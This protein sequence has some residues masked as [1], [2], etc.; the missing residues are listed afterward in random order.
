MAKLL[1]TGETKRYVISTFVELADSVLALSY[2]YPNLKFII[3][4]HG[5][6]NE[7]PPNVLI[8]RP[9]WYRALYMAGKVCAIA[10][11]T[12][13]IGLIVPKPDEIGLIQYVNAFYLGVKSE[14]PSAT[15]GL[16]TVDFWN[17]S[18]AA[19]AAA[20]SLIEWGASCMTA[21]QG[22]AV[23]YQVF[24]DHNLPSVGLA[25]NVRIFS[26]DMVWT[27]FLID[28]GPIF[29]NNLKQISNDTLPFGTTIMYNLPEVERGDWGLNVE[30]AVRTQVDAHVANINYNA[31]FALFCKDAFATL[32]IPWPDNV[33]TE[34][35][36]FG[37]LLFNPSYIRVSPRV[38]LVAEWTTESATNRVYWRY[39]SAMSIIILCVAGVLAVFC[40]YVMPHIVYYRDS[41]VYSIASW[42]VVLMLPIACLFQLASIVPYL[43]IPTLASCN[44]RLWLESIGTILLLGT[45]LA[46]N[47]KHYIW[48]RNGLTVLTK[49]YVSRFTVSPYELFVMWLLPL[50]LANFCI[51]VFYTTLTPLVPKFPSAPFLPLGS[52][53]SQCFIVQTRAA[54]IVWL[55]YV[56]LLAVANLC[57]LYVLKN[58]PL[59]GGEVVATGAIVLNTLVF[60]GLT[61]FVATVVGRELVTVSLIIWLKVLV[62]AVTLIVLVIP[63]WWA[64]Q[65]QGVTEE[66][67]NIEHSNHNESSSLASVSR[68]PKE[69][70]PEFYSDSSVASSSTISEDEEDIDDH[71]TP[72]SPHSNF[73]DAKRAKA[74]ASDSPTNTLAPNHVP[75]HYSPP[76]SSSD[77]ESDTGSDLH[78][79]AG[80]LPPIIH[81]E[82]EPSS[83]DTYEDE[84][85]PHN[86]HESRYP[87][88]NV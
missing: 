7:V 12:D 30:R 88:Q 14:K 39:K 5:H 28:M 19:N 48:K 80:P 70:I 1:Q 53:E 16:A 74:P 26:G 52:V 45:L 75:T 31:S 54:Q 21:V 38:E 60:G 49:E 77:E 35:C 86:M 47:Y 51:V 15:V 50:M 66:L 68:R 59:L 33:T 63:K 6:V 11:A 24:R 81:N 4:H 61:A 25:S 23:A 22:N 76:T 40:L 56:I 87:D 36:L 84:D 79:N 37:D 41:R 72:S 18:I 43:D 10:S 55:S 13:K 64:I 17:A 57:F 2:G 46:R 9:K 8:I 58:I 71:E 42:L 3:V 44:L 83:S 85:D 62:V 27:S 29:L 69:P 67:D 65:V 32:G 73:N 82:S 34:N 78:P 20:N